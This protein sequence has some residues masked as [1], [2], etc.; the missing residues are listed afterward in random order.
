M[1]R[2][3]LFSTLA[4]LLASS[5]VAQEA[6]GLQYPLAVAADEN[7]VIYVADL[8][9]PGIWK[10]T[11]GK[12]GIFFQASKR[13]R[14]PLNRVRC[15]AIDAE[16]RLLA[17]DSATREIYRFSA[18]G[19]PE[20]LTNGYI[21][22]PVVLA[23]SKEGT[24]YVS[25]LESE[26]I[27]SMPAGGLAEGEEPTEV[28]VLAGVRGLA[29]DPDGKLIAATTLEDPIRRVGDDGKLEVLVP[30]RPFQLP[31]QLVIAQEGTMYV[32]DNYAGAIW[33]IPRGRRRA[34]GIRQ[35][36]A[37][38]QTG[39]TGMARRRFARCRPACEEGVCGIAGGDG[40]CC[41]QV[42]GD[43]C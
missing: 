15:L 24:I 10:I 40:D 23:V 14:T 35:R 6:A 8:H 27:W 29:F 38:R 12:A 41:C 21:G 30:G 3:L 5:A 43:Q 13:F 20:P 4:I 16:G 26:R 33:K 25:D 32:A 9:L 42:I 31:H 28:A 34:D 1:I 18:D 7:G 36:R 19:K 22:I 2:T 39:R 37:A 11:D 17:G